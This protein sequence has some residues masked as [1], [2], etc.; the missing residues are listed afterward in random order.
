MLA[1]DGRR[2][3][4][5]PGDADAAPGRGEPARGPGVAAPPLT[6]GLNVRVTNY[7]ESKRLLL[8]AG[9]RTASSLINFP[10]RR[11]LRRLLFFPRRATARGDGGGPFCAGI[12]NERARCGAPLVAKEKQRRL[13]RGRQLAASSALFSFFSPPLQGNLYEGLA[14]PG[15]LQR[16]ALNNGRGS[17][18]QKYGRARRTRRRI[19]SRG[20][21]YRFRA[22]KHC[23]RSC[24]SPRP[25]SMLLPFVVANKERIV[26]IAALP[27]RGR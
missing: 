3:Q 4:A 1:G 24:L 22:R 18:H 20:N 21:T 8:P 14:S 5:T 7:L 2:W 23:F 26:E 10:L 16:R 9:W 13:S 19:M 17:P 12:I 25:H 27:R 11:E 6:L 15:L